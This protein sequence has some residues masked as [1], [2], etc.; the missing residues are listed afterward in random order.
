DALLADL[1]D[2]RVLIVLD[3]CEH[4]IE[5]AAMFAEQIIACA[6]DAHV[7][8]TSREP[9][10]EIPPSSPEMTAAEALAFP[11]VELFVERAAAA[12]DDFELSDADAPIVAS[13][14]RKLDG[15]ALAIELA[16][17]RID[18]FGAHGLL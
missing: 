6:P 10:L 7:L 12:L 17:S 14:C 15:V 5:A 3:S 18:A 4:L 11:A 9:P 16:A 1:R 2:R 8:A 13:I